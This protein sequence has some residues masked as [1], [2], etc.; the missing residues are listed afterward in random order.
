MRISWLL[1]PAMA[2]VDAV[3]I[4]VDAAADQPESL[5]ASD[6]QYAHLSN[7]A[8]LTVIAL[9]AWLLWLFLAIGTAAS[10]YFVPNVAGVA[11][12]IRM[13]AD[14]A[15]VCCAFYSLFF[16]FCI[17]MYIVWMNRSR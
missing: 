6:D 14:V 2:A 9:I 11:R 5:L 13:R 1:L 8:P 4:A 17:K 15:G 16:I 3:M 7:Y 10:D 12:L